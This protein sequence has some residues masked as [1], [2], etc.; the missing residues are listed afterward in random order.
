[1][2]CYLQNKSKVLAF[3][4]LIT[5]CRDFYSLS[6]VVAAKNIV[7][8]VVPNKRINNPTGADSVKVKKLLI[9]TLKIVLDSSIHLPVF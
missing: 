9:A 6:E 8:S 5:V 1:M 4:N 3:D 7:A 2:L